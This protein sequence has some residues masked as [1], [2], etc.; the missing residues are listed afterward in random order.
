M[1]NITSRSWHLKFG[2]HHVSEALSIYWY[3]P[4]QV[5]EFHGR[6]GWILWFITS[7]WELWDHHRYS[8][9]SNGE[10]TIFVRAWISGTWSALRMQRW[11]SSPR[12]HQCKSN[13]PG[14]V[15][16]INGE[17]HTTDPNGNYVWIL[18]DGTYNV[19]V[20][21]RPTHYDNITNGIVLPQHA[22]NHSV[23]LGLNQQTISDSFECVRFHFKFL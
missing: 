20:S 23:V 7:C 1:V 13:V 17:S 6:S 15:V 21:K 4:G 11:L 3:D 22:T 10:H 12:I 14:S 18:L 19:T 9:L 16:T 5:K 2:E 8:K